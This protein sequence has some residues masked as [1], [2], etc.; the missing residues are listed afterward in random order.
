MDLILWRHAEAREGLAEGEDVARPLTPKGER[1]AQRMAHWLNH[2]L[3]ETARILVSPAVRTE[4]TAAALKRKYKLMPELLP[5]RSV[6]ELLDIARWPDAKQPVLVV[7]HQPTLGLTAGYLL[8]GLTAGWTV[9]KG[10]VWWLRRRERQ[11][12]VEV[13]LHAVI[14][15]EQA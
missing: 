7:G 10:S 3:P 11:G 12:R 14:S 6:T 5:E 8:A 4:Q 1:Q 9:R 13:V 2:Q 15:P